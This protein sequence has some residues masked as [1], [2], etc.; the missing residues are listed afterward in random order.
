[1]YE[2]KRFSSYLLVYH[3]V[4][5][6]FYQKVNFHLHHH[7]LMNWA[8]V[9]LFKIHVYPKMAY[10]R[11]HSLRIILQEILGIFNK[12][13]L[14]NDPTHSITILYMSWLDYRQ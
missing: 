7:V 4:N 10:Y 1:M 11:A 5:R 6:Y 8:V 13:L 14:K 9:Y 12:L 2:N 3:N